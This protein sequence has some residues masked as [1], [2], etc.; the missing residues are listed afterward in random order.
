MIE[1]DKFLNPDSEYRSVPFWSLNDKFEKDEL[2][3]QIREM[4]EQGIGGFFMHPRWGMKMEY[5]GSDY[6][7]VIGECIKEAEKLGMKPWLYDEDRFPSGAAGGKVVAA[8][9]E[10]SLKALLINKCEAKNIDLEKVY[11]KIFEIEEQNFLESNH[12]KSNHQELNKQEVGLQEVSQQGYKDM[13]EISLEELKQKDINVITFEVIKMPKQAVFNENSY[14]D[15][16]CKEAVDE[17]I[18]ITHEKYKE[19]FGRDFK[20]VIPGIFTDEPYFLVEMKGKL[21]L[22]WSRDFEATF[23]EGKGY[24]ICDYLPD[25]IL[26]TKSAEMTRF[27][28]WDVMVGLFVKSFTENIYNWCEKN[29]LKFTGHFWEH[30]F[31]SPLCNG[32]VM[33]NYEFMHYPGIDLLFN[34][35]ENVGQFSND[36]IVKEVSSVANQLK[37]ERV[38]SETYGA[39]GWELNFADQKR[40]VDWQFSLGINLVCQHLLHYSLKGFRKRDFALSFFDQPWWKS[41]RVLGDYIARISYV[42][43]QGKFCGDILVLHPSSTIWSQFTIGIDNQ[44]VKRI[45]E[46]AKWVTKTLNELHYLYD[47]GDDIIM[48][49]H[50]RVNDNQIVV[51]EMSYKTVILPDLTLLRKSVF[52]LLKQFYKNGGKIIVLNNQP[53]LLDGAYSKEVEDFFKLSSVVKIQS[54]K[55][56]LD[57]ALKQIKSNKVFLE[58]L[59]DEMTDEI[60]CTK[61]K[62]E[63]KEILFICNIGKEKKYNLKLKLDNYFDIETWD[64]VSGEKLSKEV[65]SVNGEAYTFVELFPSQSKLLILKNNELKAKKIEAK[66]EV[67]TENKNS[68]IEKNVI[69]LNKWIV[70]RNNFNAYPLKLCRYKLNQNEW[71][72]IVDVLEVDNMLGDSIGLGYRGIF[73]LQPW[74]YKDYQLSRT[75][76]VEVEYAFEVEVGFNGELQ[77]AAEASDEFE[78]YV[79]GFLCKT[80]GEYYINRAFELHDISGFIKDGENKVLLVNNSYG[81]NSG[82]E[83]VFLVG[84]F[85]LKKEAS[86]FI[87]QKEEEILLGD[88]TK[89][90]YP[91]YSGEMIYETDFE[92]GERLKGKYILKLEDLNMVIAKIKVNDI[93]A[94]LLAWEPYEADISSVIKTGKNTLS[95]TVINSLQNLLGSHND[96]E[97]PGISTPGSFAYANGDVRFVKAG[98]SGK[99]II[100]YYIN[101]Y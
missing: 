26:N 51:V 43:S 40:I 41:Y 50:A 30:E 28:F 93:E 39:S 69:P 88:F 97:T 84:G 19:H 25:L 70:N 36:L 74:M 52:E 45:G 81:V 34:T 9:D 95:I 23:S 49:R 90:G 48:E 63:D 37:K 61:R 14:T 33:P 8:N 13:G 16:C 99:G 54:V 18:K 67:N 17:F 11:L 73:S 3:K 65:C 83:S 35:Q 38:V 55:L 47:I 15:L 91:Y 82:I 58:S 53:Y 6:F 86:R 98:F 71:S 64:A 87:L 32:S 21:L 79:N 24:S 42:L 10:F 44:E 72:E 59:D 77:L 5:L 12:Q 80:N 89:C 101:M 60:Y 20:N 68:V 1:F 76:R 96:I 78:I 62:L 29:E 94:K 85:K 100:E 31:P 22:P 27:D 75:E 56:D 92:I 2:I 7:N 46:T 57:F 66:S 4:K